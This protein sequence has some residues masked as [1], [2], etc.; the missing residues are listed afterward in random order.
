MPFTFA[1][2]AIVFPINRLF[3]TR[4]SLTGLIIGSMIP[5]FEGFLLVTDVKVYSH[6]WHGMFWLDMPMGLALAFLFHLVIRDRLIDNLP[7]FFKRRLIAYKKLDW[8][9]YFKANVGLVLLSFLI[10]IFSHILWDDFTH[11]NGFFVRHIPFLHSSYNLTG[12]PY[13][14]YKML[15]LG[16]SVLGV[17]AV[18]IGIGMLQQQKRV[19]KQS[20]TIYWAIVFCITAS[21]VAFRF[22]LG[23][24]I[25]DFS[26]L[27]ITAMSGGLL[28]VTMA[29]IL[30]QEIKYNPKRG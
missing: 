4:F 18:L 3:R 8:N 23:L 30:T 28:G 16:T 27:L 11:L 24:E 7:L 6:T 26:L 19:H 14:V 10:G 29:S 9:K 2:P 13:P 15:Q 17:I 21:F 25:G 1:H 22:F 12:E 20:N 5:D